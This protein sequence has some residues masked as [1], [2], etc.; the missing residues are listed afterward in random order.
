[1]KCYKNVFKKNNLKDNLGFFINLGIV[2]LFIICSFIFIFKSFGQ[3]YL[4][5]KEI[6][7]AKRNT[8]FK[9]NI[10][11][12]TRIK[13]KKYKKNKKLNKKN[14]SNNEDK[15]NSNNILTD[16]SK[17]KIEFK[18]LT[19]DIM[20]SNDIKNKNIL[21]YK[22]YELNSL[23]F[24][25]ALIYDKRNF[26]QYYISSI[27][28]NNLLLFSFIPIKDYNVM[29]IKIFLFFFFFTLNLTV[30]AIFFNDDTMHKI[31]ID[32]GKYNLIYQIPQILYSSIISG[33]FNTLIKYLSLSQD[34]IMDFKHTSGINLNEKGKKLL[35]TLKI[36]FI[37]FFIVTTLFLMFFWFYISCFCGIYKNTQF[38]LMKDSILGFILSLFD[39]FWQCLFLGIVRIYS[40]KNK[41]EYL[42][43]FYLFFEN[44]S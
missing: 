14:I 42:Y 24:E 26:L 2:I 31:Y 43:K 9:K 5:I 36:K 12:T 11:N 17:K 30:N 33:I 29:I 10:N 38:H 41:K 13:K 22:D 8:K 15:I 3:L 27:K 25:K 7:L 35:I 19:N 23:D 39:P 20:L 4:D 37:I 18:N 1:M 28:I 44:L 6:I 21:E 16:S 32:G 34:N 40:L